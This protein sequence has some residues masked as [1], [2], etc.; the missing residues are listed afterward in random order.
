MFESLQDRL[1]G[2]I[3]KVKGYG[4]IT[5]DNISEVVREIRLA[6]LEADVNY[7]VVKEFIN[8][9]KQLNGNLD[10]RFNGKI[11][12][13]LGRIKVIGGIG[14]ISTSEMFEDSRASIIDLRY[15]LIW[16]TFKTV[17]I[18]FAFSLR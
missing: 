14:L 11:R 5:E 3:H 15:V 4:K 2:I 7:K 16:D 8:K 10:K 18:Y 9:V 13:L 12:K 6:L 17:D 1:E